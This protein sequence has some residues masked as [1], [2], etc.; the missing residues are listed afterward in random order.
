MRRTFILAVGSTAL[1]ALVACATA[2]GDDSSPLPE[3]DAGATAVPEA[4]V[5]PDGGSRPDDD[6]PTISWCS[7]AGW[8]ATALPDPD[9]NVTDIWPFDARAFAVA[10][11]ATLGTKVLE[12][13]EATESWAY[14]DDNSQNAYGRGQYAGKIW[15]PNE[16]EIYYGVAPSFLYRGTRE[17]PS[18]PWTWESTRLEYSGRD[19]GPGRD[20]GRASY[21]KYVNYP[22]DLYPA[23]GVWGTSGDDVYAWYANTIFHRKSEDGGAPTWVAEHVVEDPDNPD[24]TFFVF[25]A[26]GTS[27]DDVWFAV[28]RG[29]YNTDSTGMFPCSVVIQRTPDDYRRIVDHTINPAPSGT[30]QA[31]PGFVQFRMDLF[32]PALGGNVS[33]PVTNPGWLTSL[34]SPRPGSVVGVLDRT[35]LGYIGSDGAGSAL[36]NPVGVRSA[37]MTF[38]PLLSSIWLH[39]DTAWLSGWGLVLEAENKPDAWA[40]G[41]GLRTSEDLASAGV[42]GGAAYSISTTVLNGAPLDRPLH[43]VRGSSNTNLWA[44]GPRYALHKTTP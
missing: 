39:G 22:T 1:A 40:A 6:A 5:P 19:F 41:L 29:R 2:G 17:S 9:L 28:G 32:I 42:D 36:T 15:A 7:D 35:S 21:R 31:K 11:S 12:W 43:Q 33:F 16:N 18:S 37:S 30:C 24:D 27:R 34:A 25:A 10:E 38:N 3:V 8:C 23:L 14:I 26:D 13:T 4:S 44:V 20:P